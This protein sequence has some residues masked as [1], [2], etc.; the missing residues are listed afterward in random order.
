MKTKICRMQLLKQGRGQVLTMVWVQEAFSSIFKYWSPGNCLTQ[1]LLKFSINKFHDIICPTHWAWSKIHF[2][3]TTLPQFQTMTGL[4]SPCP[5][6]RGKNLI[7]LQCAKGSRSSSSEQWKR[8]LILRMR[9]H[10]SYLKVNFKYHWLKCNLHSAK[11][12]E[13]KPEAEWGV[14]FPSFCDLTNVY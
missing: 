12:H 4:S 1:S 8:H 10:P 3:G 6:P 9:S 7:V 5:W 11:K 13:A 2:I 14:V